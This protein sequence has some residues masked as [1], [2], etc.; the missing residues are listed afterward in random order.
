MARAAELAEQTILGMIQTGELKPGDAIPHLKLASR[1]G[2]SNNPV[3]QSLRRLEGLGVLE[4]MPSGE[5][6]VR[7]YSDRE[8]YAAYAVREAVEGMAARFCAQ[9]GTDEEFA[10]LE[11]R[12]RKL[13][14]CYR[15]GE[16]AE[17]EEQE[18]HR[19][20]VGFSHTPFLEHLHESA[21][22]LRSTFRQHLIQG[23]EI[24]DMVGLHK[25]IIDALLARDPD[26]AEEAMRA[27]IREARESFVQR[28]G[29]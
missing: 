6:R 13:E 23:R 10:I 14:E 3:I 12:H 27:H 24:S 2:I 18:L 19:G 21:M 7:E 11:F 4:H 26:A 17:E 1:L 8:V 16:W 29:V 22:I 25:P 9:L 20:V 15:R 5:T 28:Q